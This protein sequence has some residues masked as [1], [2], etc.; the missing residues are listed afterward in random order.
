MSAPH[1]HRSRPAMSAHDAH[2]KPSS[3][4]DGTNAPER[5]REERCKTQEGVKVA[6]RAGLSGMGPDIALALLD[7][8]PYGARLMVRDLLTAGQLI[9]VCLYPTG[10]AGGCRQTALVVWSTAAP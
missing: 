4:P 7:V 1:P 3:Q 2:A 5:R 10:G 8:S 9:E 6:C